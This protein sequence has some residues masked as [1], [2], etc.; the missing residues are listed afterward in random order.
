[1][2]NFRG[3]VIA[4]LHARGH[5]TLVLAP[6]DDFSARLT[7]LGCEYIPI[8]VDSRGSNPLRD[9]ALTKQLYDV[10]RAK[11]PDITFN[12]TIKC[13]IFASLAARLA[14]VR[15]IPVITGT[16]Q[17]F[18][19]GM[20][21]KYAARGLY[22]FALR[23]VRDVWFLNDEDE[24][25]FA[26]HRLIRKSQSR[27]LPGEGID[28]GS[29]D[30]R[31]KA[32]SSNTGGF[33]FLFASRLLWEKG[34]GIFADA[35]RKV[36]QSHPDAQ[37]RLLGALWKQDPTAVSK[38]AIDAWEREGIL[39]YLGFTDDV[40]AVMLESDCVVL[41]SYYREGIPRVLLEA[42][43]LGLPI[44]TTDNVGCRDVVED[45]RNGFLVRPRDVDDL[46]EKM[47]RMM[48]ATEAQRREMGRYGREKAQKY[49]L[50]IVIGHYV[51]AVESPNA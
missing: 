45:G 48:A 38:E 2:F 7:A 47:V 51:T 30:A 15:A 40:T 8:H 39:T 19:E 42:A 1:V 14:G 33:V 37:F 4:A 28:V 43:A 34:V 26:R 36:K 16:G 18:A 29:L 6:P 41:P 49:D 50:S 20:W 13:A 35:A 17:A 32:R 24:R 21:L 5:R 27:V 46:A 23:S 12:Y 22:W 3:G 25:L 44:I 9:I 10:F 11:R 31:S